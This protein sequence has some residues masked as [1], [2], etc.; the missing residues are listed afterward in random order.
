M[1]NTKKIIESEKT[2]LDKIVE[3]YANKWPRYRQR[4]RRCF[5]NGKPCIFCNQLKFDNSLGIDGESTEAIAK[6]S[7]VF[8]VMP[9]RPNLDT[10]YEWSLKE[11]LMEG[12]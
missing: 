11:Y 8:V 6:E 9:F 10:F 7:S 1:D 3:K 12:F 2:T 5:M 4:V